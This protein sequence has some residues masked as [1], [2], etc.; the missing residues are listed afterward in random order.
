VAAL[1]TALTPQTLTVPVRI[2]LNAPPEPALLHAAVRCRIRLAHDPHA[3]IIPSSA[4]V[5]S[6]VARRGTLMVAVDGRA[7]RR[8]VELGIRSAARVEV[9]NGLS[10]GDQVLADGQ[11]AL[12]DGTRIEAVQGSVE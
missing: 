9:V 7:Q 5:S 12:P 4:L 11:Y 2:V 1:I 6:R 8:A 3:L 10:E